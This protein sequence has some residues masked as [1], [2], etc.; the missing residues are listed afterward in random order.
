[1]AG[2]KKWSGENKPYEMT[3]ADDRGFEENDLVFQGV[4]VTKQ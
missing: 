1:M 4:E 2:W 3:E